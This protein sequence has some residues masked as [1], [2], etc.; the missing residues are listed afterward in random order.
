M[1]TQ[2]LHIFGE[3]CVFYRQKKTD[4]NVLLTL[5]KGQTVDKT[6]IFETS[7]FI[8]TFRLVY[9]KISTK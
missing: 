6:M 8:E 4:V 5:K 9:L 2:F 1:F 3:Y 7:I